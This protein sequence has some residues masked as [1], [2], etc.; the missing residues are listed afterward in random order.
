MR[1][2][3]EAV[4][5]LFWVLGATVV[6]AAPCTVSVYPY[7][8][9]GN[10]LDATL[11]DAVYLPDDDRQFVLPKLAKSRIRMQGRLLIL[12]VEPDAGQPIQVVIEVK[13]KRRI[14]KTFEFI[15]CGQRFSFAN[16]LAEEGNGEGFSFVNGGLTGC[17][18][19]EGWWVRMMPMFSFSRLTPIAEADVELRSGRFTIQGFILGIRHV[20]VVGRGSEVVHAVGVNVVS[21]GTVAVLTVDVSG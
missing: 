11:R 10:R 17:A 5:W 16:G 20:L 1:R 9:K 8:E 18:A 6:S 14:A 12:P 3:N 2:A 4:T 19:Y 21:G 15:H 13:G 7:D